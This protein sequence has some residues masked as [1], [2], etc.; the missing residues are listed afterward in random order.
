MEVVLWP[1]GPV[2]TCIARSRG[3]RCGAVTRPLTASSS[4]HLRR[5]RATRRSAAG[6]TGARRAGHQELRDVFEFADNRAA[7]SRGRSAAILP[8][9]LRRCGLGPLRRVLPQILALARPLFGSLPYSAGRS[10][11]AGSLV[12]SGSQRF[13]SRVGV[14]ARGR[15]FPFLSSSLT[16]L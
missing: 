5:S 12:Q 2:D 16:P 4:V 3:R 8:A 11:L 1:C 14:G 6:R 7:F 13:G 9:V 10:F 15:V